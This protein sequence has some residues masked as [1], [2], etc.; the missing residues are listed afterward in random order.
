MK[1]ELQNGLLTIR[2]FA[3]E[4]ADYHLAHEDEEIQKW[5]SGGKSTLESVENWIIRNQES[6][7][8]NG[9]IYNFAV[10]YADNLIG[11]VEANSDGVTIPELEEGDVNISYAIYSQE[12]GKGFATCAITLLLSF[13]K[14]KGFK[15]A[16]I[17]VEHD[18]HFSHGVPKRLGFTRKEQN[19]PNQKYIIYTKTLNQK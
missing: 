19:D 1:S 18:N 17:R 14:E 13:V 16:I 4:D 2:P 15:R 11:M 12:R 5:L 8:Q 9:P 7:K 3:L 10:T 6:W